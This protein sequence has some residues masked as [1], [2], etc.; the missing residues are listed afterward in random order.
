VIKFQL[1]T[2][3]PL[4]SVIYRFFLAGLILL[5]Y[6][7][8]KKIRLKYSLREHLWL[9]LQGIF[10]FGINYWLVYLAELELTSG[11]IAIVF[12]S[13]IFLNVINGR[14]FLKS[15]VRKDVILGGIFGL[16]GVALI[17]REEL[18]SFDFTK[19]TSIALLIAVAAA[20]LASLGNILSARNQ[21]NR[22]PVLQSNI[23]S[24][25]YGALSA[26]LIAL[27]TSKT[28]N[29]D[30]SAVYIGSLLYLVIFGS[31][32]AFGTYLTL[33]GK[34]GADKSAYIGLIIPVF[35]LLL[36][37]I[38]EGYTWNGWIILGIIFTISGNFIA[39]KK[40]PRFK[41]L[42]NTSTAPI[43]SNQ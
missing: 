4:V 36:S 28:F 1:G 27:F 29:F 13:I 2:V 37:T 19:Q 5:I 6:G 11:L 39:L 24:M 41:L 20:Y 21:K 8:I 40:N 26:F 38:F 32:V 43:E 7:K 14:I 33:L 16:V 25:L 9:A 18:G 3:D 30:F 17:F 22:L 15:P 42:L 23:Y 12:T 10:L 35:A 31:I 34:I